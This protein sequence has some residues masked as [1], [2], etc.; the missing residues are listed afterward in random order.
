MAVW[1][2]IGANTLETLF[3]SKGR[4]VKRQLLALNHNAIAERLERFIADNHI[5]AL[6]ERDPGEVV[7]GMRCPYCGE[8][9]LKHMNKYGDAAPV[10]PTYACGACNGKCYHL[11]DDYL[12]FL[13]DNNTALFTEEEL[14]MMRADKGSFMRELR[15]YIIRVFASKH[16]LVARD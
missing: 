5:E 2:P 15:A 13:V 6:E 9:A 1:E 16:M 10:M 8:R 14:E 7:C 3:D 4:V 12:A 11:S